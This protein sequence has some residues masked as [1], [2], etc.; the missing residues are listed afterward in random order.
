MRAE[1]QAEGALTL[2]SETGE[3]PLTRLVG[4]RAVGERQEQVERVAWGEAGV[5]V[6]QR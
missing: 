6:A 5:G 3:P 4:T 1:A 2:T